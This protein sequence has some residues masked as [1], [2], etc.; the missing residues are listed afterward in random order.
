MQRRRNPRGR[1]I[2][3]WNNPA[4]LGIYRHTHKENSTQLLKRQINCTAACVLRVM[5]T[6]NDNNNLIS[7]HFSNAVLLLISV[8]Y[9]CWAECT[10]CTY[11]HTVWWCTASVQI[12]YRQQS[13]WW[14]QRAPACEYDNELL[15]RFCGVGDVLLWVDSILLLH[16]AKPTPPFLNFFLEAGLLHNRPL[17]S[18]PHIL[19]H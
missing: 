2:E 14:L 11:V 16:Q 17:P 1:K 3:K 13:S 18:V 6:H 8:Q 9:Y 4:K 15:N 10:V 7:M 5:S 12:I 19:S